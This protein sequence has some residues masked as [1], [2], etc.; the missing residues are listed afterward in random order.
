MR[1]S[2]YVKVDPN[3][4]L[5]YIY[6]DDN[7]Y[8]E[9]YFILLNRRN[10]T[11]QFLSSN[12]NLLN[13]ADYQLTEVDVLANKYAKLDYT[14]YPYIQAVPYNGSKFIRYD[15]LRIHFPSSYVFNEYKGFALDIYT[16][17]SLN[18]KNI[19]LSKFFFDITNVDS[20]N[21]FEYNATPLSYME[22]TWDKFIEIQFPSP[23]VVSLQIDEN[24][25]PLSDSIN[26]HLD[27]IGISTTS[28]ILIDFKFILDIQTVNSVKQYYLSDDI[29]TSFPNVPD[30]E[31]L[32]VSIVDSPNGDFYEICG[33]Y[34]GTTSGFSTFI[35][36]SFKLGIRY[37][38]EYTVTTYEENIKKRGLVY[39]VNENF[40]EPIE[41]RPIFK[42]TTTTAMIDVELRLIDMV[43]DSIIYRRGSYSMLP[44]EVSKFSANLTKI[45][46]NNAIKPK[47]YNTRIT[48]SPMSNIYGNAQVRL[49]T[50]KVLYPVLIEN[51]KV[52]AKSDN[53][54]V[55]K[56]IWRGMGKTRIVI[57]PFDNIIKFT[58]AKNV[59]DSN[60]NIN[61]VEYFDMSNAS[62]V[63][64]VFKS[65]VSEVKCNIYRN[66]DIVDLSKGMLIFKIPQS[67][68]TDIR[69]IYN[70]KVNTFYITIR[71]NN[72][73][74]FSI[75]S[76]TFI[77]FDDINNINNIN[78]TINAEVE[79][80][81]IT[82]NT[83]V[84]TATITLQ[85]TIFETTTTTTT[86]PNITITN[87]GNNTDAIFFTP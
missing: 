79:S 59:S 40:G 52:I 65:T 70:S 17:D 27:D 84:P 22:K 25:T 10:D 58:I 78:D 21:L 64:L 54:Q 33:L 72:N 63:S 74:T 68:I 5:E 28:P 1:T 67:K 43:D 20:L 37:R 85:N 71:N 4:L 77:M 45:N 47:I 38:V 69:N 48:S 56:D 29:S 60:D 15:S 46:I 36:D 51:N 73:E 2:K 34:N 66:G 32:S 50:V 8:A 55:G 61:N 3:I 42:N 57:M 12:V 80:Y 82:S 30:F 24:N 44:N 13:I 35:N 7:I 11:R 49:E 53:V 16:L 14:L 31:N 81:I 39:S 23:Y 6:N 9:D 83:E 62:E 76:G 86:N 19:Y 26:S 41:Y 87:N 18:D 75:Y